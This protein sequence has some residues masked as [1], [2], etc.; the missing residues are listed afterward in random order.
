MLIQLNEISRHNNTPFIGITLDEGETVEGEEAAEVSALPPLGSKTGPAGL[1]ALPYELSFEGGYFDTADFISGV[2][3][4]V[5]TRNGRLR[6]DGRLIT[7]DRFE[8]AAPKT[9]LRPRELEVKFYVTAYATPAGQ[10]LTAGATPAGP[11]P[12]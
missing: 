3:S 9:T 5:Q 10:G 2:H 11:A 6:A 7:F 8:M 1:Q 12:K 4:L